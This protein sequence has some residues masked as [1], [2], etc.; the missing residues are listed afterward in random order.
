MPTMIMKIAPH[1]LLVFT[2]QDLG[3]LTSILTML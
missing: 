2:K 1:Y 3:V